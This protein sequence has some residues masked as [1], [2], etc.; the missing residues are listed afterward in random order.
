MADITLLPGPQK[1]EVTIDGAYSPDKMAIL[2]F[3]IG[4]LIEKTL[5]TKEFTVGFGDTEGN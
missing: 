2:L 1:I 4:K 5:N 3:A